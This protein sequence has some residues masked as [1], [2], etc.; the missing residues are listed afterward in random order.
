MNGERIRNSIIQTILPGQY[1]K[2]I[3]PGQPDKNGVLFRKVIRESSRPLSWPCVGVPA[4]S[5]RF[6]VEI[7]I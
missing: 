1:S 2:M 5:A 4:L 7:F 6:P 3:D